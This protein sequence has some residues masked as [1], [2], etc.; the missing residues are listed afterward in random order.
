MAGTTGKNNAVRTLVPLLPLGIALLHGAIAAPTS[1]TAERIRTAQ[2]NRLSSSRSVSGNGPAP[3]LRTGH[4]VDWWFVFKFNSKAFPA[5][6]GGATRTCPFGGEVQNYKTFG[7]QFVYA[8]SEN[9]SLQ[10]GADC[11]GDTTSQPLGATFDEVY[12]SSNYYVIWNDQFYDDPELEGC[13]K[14][15]GSPWGHSKGMLAWSDDGSGFVL[16][17]TTPSWPASGNKEFPRKT[18]GNTLGCIEDNNVMVS[19]D[20]FALRLNKNDVLVV[21]K[22]LQNSSVVTDPENQQIVKNGGPADVQELVKNLGAKSQSETVLNN[23]LSTG[24]TLISKPSGLHVPPWQMVSAL[25]DGVDLRTATWWANPAIY[26]TTASTAIDCW[27]DS[28]GNP[29]AVQIATTG[30]WDGTE[31]GLKGGPGP[32]FNHAKLGVSISDGQHYS[33]FGD[34]N[35][36][37]ATS[38]ANCG[39][40]QNGRGGLFYVIENADLSEGLKSLISGDTAP[41]KPQ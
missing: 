35:Q 40:S 41:T 16:Q 6:E 12:N 27:D 19:Q 36:Q 29:G 34:M 37:G 3:L 26:T 28:L 32:N 4:A 20:F 14:Q 1:S 7:Q 39:S 22:S 15:C 23:T 31:F 9:P 18:D 10:K 5:C 33:I 8:S 25:L 30:R 11:V 13:T 2:T 17:V 38:G 21:L 24:V